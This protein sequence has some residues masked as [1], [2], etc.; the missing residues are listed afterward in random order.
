MV[1]INNFCGFVAGGAI[2]QSSA[3]NDL[4]S[5]H[6]PMAECFEPNYKDVIPPMQLRRMSKAIRLSVAAVKYILPQ[7]V[8]ASSISAIN[9]GTT[10]GMLKDS[11][12]FLSK[13]VLQDEEMLNPTS[14]IQSTQNTVGGQ[15]ALMLGC[16]APNMTFVQ[17]GHSFEHALLDVELSDC[18]LD[19]YILGGVDENTP[20][21]Y[22]ILDNLVKIYAQTT[23]KTFLSEGAA[24]L[25]LSKAP[26]SNSLAQITA[27]AIFT[28]RSIRAFRLQILD[29]LNANNIDVEEHV[30]LI[31]GDA[32]NNA[33]AIFYKVLVRK[34]LPNARVLNYK[35]YTS[36]YPTAAAAGLCYS[37]KVLQEQ[38][39]DK[40]LIVQNYHDDWSVFLLEAIH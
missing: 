13:M 35:D 24:Y 33:L 36:D 1:Y 30:T 12:S 25:Q 20:L 31:T 2:L 19:N 21:F 28:T 34:L 6:T 29:F 39:L 5:I 32:P 15:V 22:D 38:N 11:E 16:T 7:D 9:I 14:F 40:V 4:K 27:N 10:Y 37:T 3:L 26:Q 17:R 8:D 18:E 23:E